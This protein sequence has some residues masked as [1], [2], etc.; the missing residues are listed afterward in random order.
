MKLQG[1]TILITGGASG[2]GQ[3]FAEALH[4]GGNKVIIAGRRRDALASTVHSHPGM[5]SVELDV[6][7]R[8]SIARASAEILRKHPSLNVLINN[9]GVMQVDD[10]AS[11]VDEELLASTIATNLLGPIRLTGALVDH[12][13]RQPSA[14]IINVSSA[15]GFVPLAWSAVYSSTKA[16]LHSYSLSLR[17]KLRGT[18]VKVVEV[19]PPWVQT[20][21]LGK[22]N[23]HDAR[24][25]PLEEFTA[26]AM[27]LLASNVE[28]VVV[29]KA[30]GLRDNVGP[31]EG[32]LVTQLN[33]LLGAVH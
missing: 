8:A 18:S 28:E 19:I 29:E 22:E 6:T 20:D 26:E 21:L 1:S 14:T 31:N 30:K 9:A 2:I 32:N 11:K 10:V 16:A 4:A 13:K 3:A 7:D 24:A 23:R 15:L 12:L 17:Y 25:M 5:E 27:R 33:D